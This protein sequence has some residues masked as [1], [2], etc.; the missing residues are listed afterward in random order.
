MALKAFGSYDQ[1]LLTPKLTFEL[2]PEYISPCKK[3]NDYIE[4]TP[5]SSDVDTFKDFN[6]R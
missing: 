2:F 3:H 6:D 1:Y 5:K 4:K